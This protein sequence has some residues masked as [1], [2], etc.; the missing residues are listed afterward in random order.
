MHHEMHF[1]YAYVCTLDVLR[2]FLLAHTPSGTTDGTAEADTD[3][4]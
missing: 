4:Y 2:V 3:D 1:L